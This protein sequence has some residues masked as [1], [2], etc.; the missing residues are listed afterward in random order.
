MPTDPLTDPP[1]D[2]FE[3]LGLQA[4]SAEFMAKIANK[5]D[6]FDKW[7]AGITDPHVARLA[8]EISEANYQR[9]NILAL[10][11]KAFGEPKRG[12]DTKKRNAP[13]GLWGHLCAWWRER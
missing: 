4:G 6:A 1:T 3:R 11:A 5:A 8:K 9:I 10:V 12:L 2:P 7:R 13:I